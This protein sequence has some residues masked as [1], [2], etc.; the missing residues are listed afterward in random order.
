M[1]IKTKFIVIP[2]GNHVFTISETPTL[3]KTKA[4]TEKLN[5]P[6]TYDS[7]KSGTI[8]LFL[9]QCND[10]LTSVGFEEDENGEFDFDEKS[11]VGM[12][13]AADVLHDID[14]K[15][16]HWAR[17]SNFEAIVWDAVPPT[18]QKTEAE[19]PKKTVETVDEKDVHWED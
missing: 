14:E 4:G 17:Y 13:F 11:L 19:Q 10:L 2:E 7:G 16:R 1:R 12:M 18:Q 8:S 15:E 6:V 5:F 9:K 3:S